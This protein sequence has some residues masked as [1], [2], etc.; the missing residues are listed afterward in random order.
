MELNKTDSE[1]RLAIERRSWESPALSDAEACV[2]AQADAD[3]L[4]ALK[5]G[6][7]RYFTAVCMGE[8][9]DEYKAYQMA[10]LAK[11]PFVMLEVAAARAE[12]QRRQAAKEMRKDCFATMFSENV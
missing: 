5:D 3:V 10:L 7:E 11:S 12:D 6:T 8:I 2:F 1:A 9:A 4:T